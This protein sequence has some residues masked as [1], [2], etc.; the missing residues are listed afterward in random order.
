M[1]NFKGTKGELKKV[2][3]HD[4]CIGIGVRTA[5]GYHEM[6]ANS[7][8]PDVE[9]MGNDEID[10]ALEIVEADMTLYAH[11]KEMLKTLESVKDLLEAYPGEAEMHL[12]ATQ[13]RDLI[14]R[15]TNI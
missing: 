5:D 15:A 12:K 10:R 6:T 3:S 7:I 11:S 1:N 4:V 2:Y 13:I 8:L 9:E 14:Q